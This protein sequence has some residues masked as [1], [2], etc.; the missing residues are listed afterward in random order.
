MADMGWIGEVAIARLNIIRKSEEILGYLRDL[1][2]FV[3]WDEKQILEQA[4]EVIT[5][6]LNRKINTP[7]EINP[8]E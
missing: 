5:S 8:P 3:N 1:Q 6:F 2:K 4:S 7:S